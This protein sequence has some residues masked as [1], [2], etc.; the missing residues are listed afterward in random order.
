MPPG[1]VCTKM[2]RR[3]VHTPQH[4][5]TKPHSRCECA[6]CFGR[7]A[8]T[9][10][11]RARGQENLI[12]ARLANGSARSLHAHGQPRHGDTH[13]HTSGMSNMHCRET[14]ND[15]STPQHID[16][17]VQLP[18]RPQAYT[19]HAKHIRATLRRRIG[20]NC[21]HTHACNTAMHENWLLHQRGKGAGAE[22]IA[23]GGPTWQTRSR[24]QQQNA[25][26]SWQEK[27]NTQNDSRGPERQIGFPHWRPQMVP[28]CTA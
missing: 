16:P 1:I 4:S 18:H 22:H 23:S 12:T 9:R 24:V 19:N 20:Q 26:A 25:T 15:A 28:H 5:Q 13:T 10:T 11:S 21:R 6:L 17:K 8:P 2:Q 27:V 14:G 7:L 3:R